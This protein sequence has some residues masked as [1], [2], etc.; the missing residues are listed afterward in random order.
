MATGE[1]REENERIQTRKKKGGQIIPIFRHD[2][3]EKRSQKSHQITS[4]SDQQ[5]QQ[6]GRIQN[7]LRKTN[8]LSIQKQKC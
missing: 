8:S 6:T 3:L 2:I 5:F 7:Q 1:A 4:R